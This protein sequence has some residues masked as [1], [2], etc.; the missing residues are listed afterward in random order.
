MIA[1]LVQDV[2]GQHRI[3]GNKS[4]RY[5]EGRWKRHLQ[6]F[7]G[8]LRGVQVTTDLLRRYVMERKAQLNKWGGAPQNSTI[9]RELALLR[10]AFYL[11]YAAT[12]P[13]IIRVPT[14]PMLQEDNTREGFLR[15]E[16]YDKLAEEAG[17]F[18]LWIRG[19]LAV[20]NTYGWRRS[21]P[22]DDLRVRQVDLVN[23]TIDLN[24]G[25]TKNKDA[26]VIKMTREVHAVI[27]MCIE[28]KGPDDRVFTRED[29]KIIGDF[30]KTWYKICCNVGLGRMACCVL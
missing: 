27:S 29:G 9:N 4:I 11:G 19:L 7:F 22:L 16:D 13:K 26:R 14:F 15:D 25:A 30:R 24:P 3:D 8:N 10:S 20:Y 17:K 21:E 5:E 28:G 1:E 2:L 12:P 23:Q 6:P 18:G